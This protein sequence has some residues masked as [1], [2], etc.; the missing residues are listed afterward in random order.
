MPRAVASSSTDETATDTASTGQGPASGGA[1]AE[2]LPAG[3]PAANAPGAPAPVAPDALERVPGVLGEIAR[4]RAGDYR[5]Y[6]DVGDG[7][8]DAGVASAERRE[9]LPARPG[10]AAALR[11]PGVAVIAEV[12]R[13]SPSQGLIRDLDPVA[14]ARA[15][16]AAGAAAVSVLTEGRHF[17]G[18]LEQL[19]A[20]AR[21]VP[22]PLLRKDFVVHPAQV[23]EARRGGASAVL[24]IAAVL[25]EALPA[26]QAFAGANAIETLVEVHDEHELALALRCGCSIIGVNNRDLRSLEVDLSLAPR[27]MREA[28]ERGFAGVL[29]AESGYRRAE[30]LRDLDGLADAVLV[31][32][33]LAASEDP[34]AALAALLPA[35]RAQSG[36][37]GNA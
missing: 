12:K 24:L 8:V 37:E 2:Q 26:Y 32:S 17:G 28:R 36:E 20:V 4:E 23:R 21:A 29:V 6:R 1:A 14:V 10:F 25:G 5:G 33:S 18:S 34:G 16:A 19:E 35:A 31:G 9:A 15:Y 7:G 30:E 27:L 3:A 11:G 22:L 13:S